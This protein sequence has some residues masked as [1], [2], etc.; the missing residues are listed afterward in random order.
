M[1]HVRCFFTNK[2]NIVLI[3]T[4]DLGWQDVGCY[5]I[6]GPSPMETPNLD[7]FAK[8]GVRKLVSVEKLILVF[9]LL[10]IGKQT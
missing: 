10:M 3:L 7:A 1:P 9:V 6:D 2:P 5:D 4:D 8:K